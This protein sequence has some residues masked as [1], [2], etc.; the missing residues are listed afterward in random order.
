MPTPAQFRTLV[1]QT[2]QVA[3]LLL[4]CYRLPGS[5]AASDHEQRVLQHVLSVLQEA[6]VEV[7]RLLVPRERQ[8]G[9]SGYYAAPSTESDT[10]SQPSESHEPDVSTRAVRRLRP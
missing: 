1:D 2:L 7:Q 6:Y 8:R 3:R 10:S 5:H 4:Q 9:A